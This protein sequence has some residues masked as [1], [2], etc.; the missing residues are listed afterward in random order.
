VSTMPFTLE[1]HIHN[2]S[3][4]LTRPFQNLKSFNRNY[5]H[6]LTTTRIFTMPKVQ[7]SNLK[8]KQNKGNN[9]INI[10]VFKSLK[11]KISNIK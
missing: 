8:E 1:Y 4:I 11:I 7:I 3:Q 9:R 2:T 6:T 10:Y 5:K